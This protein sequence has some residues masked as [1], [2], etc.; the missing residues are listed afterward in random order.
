MKILLATDGFERS[1]AATHLLEAAGRRAGNTVT[2]LSV[3]AMASSTP[4]WPPPY[5][6]AALGE[7]RERAKHIA[8]AAADHLHQAG[9]MAEAEM[10]EGHPGAEIVAMAERGGYGLTLLG[11]S[12]H[13]WLGTRL[14]GS[15]GTF[16]LHG[17]PASVL[18]VQQ[19]PA[20]PER[21]RVLIATDGSAWSRFAVS[22]F[23]AFADP[24]RCDVHVLCVAEPP[25]RLDSPNYPAGILPLYPPTFY[26]QQ[27]YDGLVRSRSQWA[28][29][30][31]DGA[32]ERLRAA[33]FTVDVAVASGSPRAILLEEATEGNFD[34]VVAGSRGLG[35]V[36][37]ALMGSVS[38]PLAHHARATLVGRSETS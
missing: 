27:D 20:T 36:R 16:V 7:D 15:T 13:G 24:G 23:E 5:L 8:S 28:Q 17:A 11:S 32:A 31:A 29:T 3:A 10:A 33:G 21:C 22:T 1:L 37:R 38:E 14:L 26:S 18:L 4:D 6:E 2:V 30:A 35:P 25:P 12:R 9:F 19:P 34:L